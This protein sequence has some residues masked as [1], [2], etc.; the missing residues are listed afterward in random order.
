VSS[1]KRG[2]QPIIFLFAGKP[3]LAAFVAAQ[4]PVALG[5]RKAIGFQSVVKTMLACTIHSPTMS[6]LSLLL[7]D[8]DARVHAIRSDRPD[9]PCTKGCDGCCRRLA[10]VPR[11]T[12]A[13]WRLLR[14][15]LA[16]LPPQRLREISRNVAALASLPAIVEPRAIACPL[17]DPVTRACPVYAQRPVACRTYGY[18]VQRER[19]LFCRDIESRVADGD[20]ADLVW[21]NHDAIDQRL[22]GLGDVRSL[23]EWFACWEHEK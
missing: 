15:G 19:G 10:E 3:R 5:A 14:D 2:V 21:G 20:C 17:L 6:T 11:L 7:V 8:I 12:A 16:A 4:S 9:W 23:T 13:E 18:Y 22:S 1:V